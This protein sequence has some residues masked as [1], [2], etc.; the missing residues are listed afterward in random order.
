MISTGAAFTCVRLEDRTARCWG[1]NRSRELGDGRLSEG[2]PELATV[3]ASPGAAST[4][5]LQ[6]ISAIESGGA[7]SCALLD[8]QSVRCWGSNA[9]AALGVGSVDE[10]GG[11]VAVTW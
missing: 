6:N 5:P 2:G 7:T 9:S 3:I 1:S 4:N 11:P 10:Q 8:D